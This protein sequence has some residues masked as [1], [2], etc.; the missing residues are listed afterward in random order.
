MTTIMVPAPHGRRLAVEISGAPR[1]VPVFVLHG[2]PGSRSGPYP[3][4]PV[5]YRQ[6]VR[7]ISY[8]RPGYGDSDRLAG[9][10]VRHAAED[11]R[12]IADF[13]G[14]DR[15]CV[16]GRSGGGPHALACAALLGRRVRRAAVLVSLAPRNAAGLDWYAGMG[17]ANVQAYQTAEAGEAALTSRLEV[18]AALMRHDPAAFLPFREPDLPESDRRLTTDHGIRSVLT[19]VFAES[20]KTS[21][22]GWVDDVLSFIADWGFDPAAID[23]PVLLWHGAADVYSPVGHT[24][25]LAERLRRSTLVIANDAA[26]FGSMAVFPEVLGWLVDRSQG[27]RTVA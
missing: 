26:H 14:I 23:V 5:L 16:L 7:L 10:T 9:R 13:L 20:V 17:E 12:A 4:D 3:R 22:D 1:G 15:F 19:T 24:M 11:V 21:G 27:W 6:A 18:H 8:D 2:T 25:W